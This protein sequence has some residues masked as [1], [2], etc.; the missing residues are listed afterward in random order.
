MAVQRK[1]EKR[2][3]SGAGVRGG[4][5]F[6]KG[7]VIRILFIIAAGIFVLL[8]LLGVINQRIFGL[9][10]ID[11][12]LKIGDEAGVVMYNVFGNKEDS[13]VEYSDQGLYLKDKTPDPNSEEMKAAEEEHEKT[14]KEHEEKVK[15]PD[16]K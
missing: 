13:P 14:L 15:N 11:G 10:F 9:S 4:G 1:E 7:K 6:G 12:F 8:C 16:K 5:G 2:R 3:P